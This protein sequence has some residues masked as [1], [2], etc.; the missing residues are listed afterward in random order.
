MKKNGIL[1]VIIGNVIV[2]SVSTF[3]MNV[4]ETKSLLGAILDTSPI[5]TFPWLSNKKQIVPLLYRQWSRL[6]LYHKKMHLIRVV[7]PSCFHL[8]YYLHPCLITNTTL[9]CNQLLYTHKQLQVLNK[10]FCFYGI[11]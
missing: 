6:L 3:V 5:T 10:P 9:L 4:T 7:I 1:G 8:R 2:A 11:Q